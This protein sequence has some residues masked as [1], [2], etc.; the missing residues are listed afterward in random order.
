MSGLLLHVLGGG[1]WQVPTVGLA[2]ALGCR[3]LVTDLYADRPAY[4][5]A[6][7]HEVV[8]VTDLS[9][10]L[11]VAR[12]YRVDGVLCD[13]TDTGVRTAAYVAEKLG[14]PGM[15]YEVACNFTDKARMRD[16]ACAAGLATPP[17]LAVR[18]ATAAGRASEYVGFPLVVKPVD[19][20]SGRGV[21]IVVHAHDI[22]EAFAEARSA[23]HSGTVILERF[24]EGVEIIV[25]G[26]CVDGESLVLGIA[27]KFP[28]A[29]NPTVSSRI[30]YESEH[31]LPYPRHQVESSA[32]AMISAMGLRNG[33]FHAEFILGER[34]V[35]PVDVAARGGG[36]MIY[37]HVIPHVSGVNAN[38][39]MIRVALG[40]PP[41]LRLRSAS[42]AAVIDFIRLPPGRILEL[43]GTGDAAH[44]PGIMGVHFNLGPGDEVG[45]LKHKDQRPGYVVAAGETTGA[46]L[47]F[48][49]KARSFLTVRMAGAPVCEIGA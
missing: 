43:T 24:V 38:E 34:G 33:I 49:A 8:D 35:V 44:S 32:R 10:T 39:A 29:D 16:I 48:A 30:L 2:K 18:E 11:E 26:F 21:N 46:A 22:H 45:D 20:Q 41:A 9:A 42:K 47:A 7:H 25:D 13:T 4:E 1:P 6:D 23:S 5:I 19:S 17:H 15:G 36:V 31:T 12:R 14:L 3:V 37:T 40:Q 27:R 28:Y